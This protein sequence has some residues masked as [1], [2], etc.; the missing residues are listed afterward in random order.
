MFHYDFPTWLKDQTGLDLAQV[1]AN[2]SEVRAD[3]ELRR[4][5]LRPPVEG[6]PPEKIADFADRVHRF[7]LLLGWQQKHKDVTADDWQS[8]KPFAEEFDR[9]NQMDTRVLTLF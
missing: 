5:R 8:F 7:M 2:G 6:V 4:K 9:R 1:K 3:A